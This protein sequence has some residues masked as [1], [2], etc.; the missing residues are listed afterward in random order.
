MFETKDAGFVSVW[1]AYPARVWFL[2]GSPRN[3]S[4]E[5]PNHARGPRALP[6]LQTGGVV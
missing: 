4:G 5:P 3:W 2:G 6:D 1:G